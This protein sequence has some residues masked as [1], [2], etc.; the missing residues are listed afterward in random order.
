MAIS[1]ELISQYI[2]P[3]GYAIGWAV[4][5]I[6]WFVSHHHANKRDLRKETRGYI[7]RLIDNLH[8]LVSTAVD[9]YTTEDSLNQDR[10]CLEI[11]F[12]IQ[13]CHQQIENFED[14]DNFKNCSTLGKIKS[15]F[16]D[17][18]EA[19]T[20]GDFEA[21][22][23]KHGPSDM[24]KCKHFATLNRNIIDCIEDLYNYTYNKKK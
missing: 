1:M 17:L 8:K 3:A 2:S 20:S 13:Q 19:I 6:G 23:R 5:G 7:D 24:E 12:L 22:N 16:N 9:Y 10:K 4:T 15:K 14:S 11:H 21:K 18:Y